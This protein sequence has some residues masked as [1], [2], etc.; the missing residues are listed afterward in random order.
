MQHFSAVEDA[1]Q[2][3]V[4]SYAVLLRPSMAEIPVYGCWLLNSSLIFCFLVATGSYLLLKQIIHDKV[5]KVNF[6]P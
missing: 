5:S 1:F 2:L 6:S 3:K 4:A